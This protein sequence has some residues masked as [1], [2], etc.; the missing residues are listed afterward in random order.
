MGGRWQRLRI[1]RQQCDENGAARANATTSQGKQEGG[2]KASVTQWQI[3]EGKVWARP[4][5]WRLEVGC[6]AIRQDFEEIYSC[7]WC[8]LF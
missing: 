1:E 8:F 5:Q 2:A 6:G 7:K 4:P 3:D